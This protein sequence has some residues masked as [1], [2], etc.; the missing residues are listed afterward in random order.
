MNLHNVKL[1]YLPASVY[2]AA[3]AR[4]INLEDLA[5][6]RYSALKFLSTMEVASLYACQTLE[7]LV[8]TIGQ[9][10]DFH[11]CWMDMSGQQIQDMQAVYS[12]SDTQGMTAQLDAEFG[13][14]SDNNLCIEAINMG[15]E[16]VG[17]VFGEGA[18]D[19]LTKDN[20]VLKLL[21][22]I[23]SKALL[24]GNIQQV[25]KGEMYGVVKRFIQVSAF[26]NLN[27]RPPS[28]VYR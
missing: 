17:V 10:G 21:T 15:P 5:K 14:A 11:Q 8:R 20:N 24:D 1:V 12:V 7:P 6:G 2:N 28:P 26:A 3:K 18:Y 13:G 16:H 25:S 9:R 27:F 23:T 4:N 19:A 22:Q